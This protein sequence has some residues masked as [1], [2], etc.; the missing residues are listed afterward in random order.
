MEDVSA[1]LASAKAARSGAA[2]ASITREK[3]ALT[4]A[5]RGIA[6]SEE[7]CHALPERMRKLDDRLFQFLVELSDAA[8]SDLAT[9]DEMSVMQDA[10]TAALSAISL[11]EKSSA[12]GTISFCGHPKHSES[13]SDS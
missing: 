10:V 9:I 2:V 7:E 11:G 3:A 13:F 12:Q 6:L 4:E 1:R 8:D 5:M